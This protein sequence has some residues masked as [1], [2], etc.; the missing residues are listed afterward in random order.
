MTEPIRWRIALLALTLVLMCGGHILQAQDILSQATRKQ[1]FSRQS[2]QEPRR[3]IHAPLSDVSGSDTLPAMSAQKSEEAAR[4]TAPALSESESGAK[5][6]DSAGL[7]TESEHT[8]FR[9]KQAIRQ[10]LLFLAVKHGFRIATDPNVRL[11][12]RGSFLKD[13]YRSVTNIGG[14]TDG[15]PLFTNYVGHPLQGAVSSFI[16]IQ[17]EPG[18]MKRFGRSKGYW[19]SRMK[20]MGWAAAHSAQFELGP[21]SEAM[22]GNDGLPNSYRQRKYPKLPGNGGICRSGHHS[23]GWDCMGRHRGCSGPLRRR[24]DRREDDKS[25]FEGRCQK[26]T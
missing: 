10:S 25:L 26:C 14:W 5:K 6:K 16:Q 23:G 13:Y 1:E 8:G 3:P 2:A 7:E 11:N 9:W 21:L 4:A 15:D 12:L 17:N 19:R 24:A 20:A 18:G 22:L